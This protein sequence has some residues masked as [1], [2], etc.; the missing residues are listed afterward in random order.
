MFPAHF[1]RENRRWHDRFCRDEFVSWRGRNW[2]CLEDRSWCRLQNA[3]ARQ[4][5][6]KN[7]SDGF[8]I[9]RSAGEADDPHSLAHMCGCGIEGEFCSAAALNLDD[10]GL[11]FSRL[12]LGGMT[13]E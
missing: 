2:N 7:L 5:L 11:G 3:H 12:T 13:R 10:H 4:L 1:R 9:V 6:L 8:G